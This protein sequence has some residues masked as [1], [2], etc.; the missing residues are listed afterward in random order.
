MGVYD[1]FLLSLML[2]VL[3]VLIMTTVT[4]E[5]ALLAV[6]ADGSLVGVVVE[7]AAVDAI[8]YYSVLLMIICRCF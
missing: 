8:H 6:V 5:S 3:V 4:M 7:V 1:V 2:K